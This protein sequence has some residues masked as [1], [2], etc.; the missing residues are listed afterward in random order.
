[1]MTPVVRL[2]DLGGGEPND[3]LT[4]A[5]FDEK[6]KGGQAERR[7]HRASSH[8]DDEPENDAE[9]PKALKASKGGGRSGGRARPKP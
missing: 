3:D 5:L 4:W 8:G 7:T 1:M 2:R 9:R 6:V